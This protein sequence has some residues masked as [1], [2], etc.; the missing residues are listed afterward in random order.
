MVKVMFPFIFVCLLIFC[1]KNK[2]NPPK[3]LYFASSY[4]LKVRNFE[5]SSI[6]ELI[7]QS[8]VIVVTSHHNPDGDAIGSAI[9]LAALLRKQD[10]EAYAMLPNDYPSFLKWIP[11]NDLVLIYRTNEQKSKE[12]I[13]RADLIFCLDYNAL[14]RT[15]DMEDALRSSH[16]KRVLIDHHVDPVLDDFDYYL[17]EI[18]IS[19]TAELVFKF[20]ESCGWNGIID[21]R[22]ATALFVGIMTDTGSFS[23]SCNYPDT[24]RI[25]A[26]LIKTGI[27]AEQIHRQ[28]YDT[29]SENRLRL[30]GFCLSEK[31]M[32]LP[33]FSTAYIALSK[34]ELERF[35][36]QIGDTE[37]I[38]NY[39]LSIESIKLAVFLTERKDRIRVSFR[40]KGALAVH[41]IAREHFNGGGHKNAAGGDSFTTL[42][43]AILKLKEVLAQY[44]GE[45]DR[46]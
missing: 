30:L 45:I 29:Y 8:K 46:S 14:N 1:G 4:A 26:S 27:N 43:N 5:F 37:G 38:V 18:E 9:A 17:T 15:N 24:F 42:E 10:K 32:V 20:A 33:E 2:I 22:V 6:K 19:S 21:D 41:V 39:A 34:A 23:F 12:I 40:S 28:V 31:L 11:G 7:S 13:E 44:K 16:G 3:F 36:Y 35:H 25:A